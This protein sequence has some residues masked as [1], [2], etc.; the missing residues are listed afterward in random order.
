MEIGVFEMRK[1]V[2]NVMRVIVRDWILFFYEIFFVDILSYIIVCF[3][4]VWV[5]INLVMF[6]NNMINFL[7]YCVGG[8][9]F[10]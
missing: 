9:N 2:F 7:F 4:L 8:E 3:V 10:R 1:V 5:I 6:M